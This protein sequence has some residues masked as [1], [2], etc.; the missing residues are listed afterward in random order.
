[1]IDIGYYQ[2]LSIIGLS[3]NYVWCTERPYALFVWFVP[4]ARSS[5]QGARIFLPLS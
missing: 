3:I 1:M 2:L 5:L 4:S